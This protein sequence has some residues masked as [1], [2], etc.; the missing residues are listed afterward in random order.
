MAIYCPQC[1]KEL[2]DDAMFCIKCGKPLQG[3]VQPTTQLVPL[4]EYCEIVP[5]LVGMGFA[6][7]FWARG[8]GANGEYE[9]A[10]ST[11]TFYIDIDPVYNKV[12]DRGPNSEAALNEL[13][14][15]LSADGWELLPGKGA[16]WC[17][18][19]LR[20]QAPRN[21]QEAL[22]LCE[23]SLQ[24]NPHN[25]IAWKRKGELLER[26]KRHDEALQAY[27]QALQ[28]DPHS[29]DFWTSK[30]TVLLQLNRLDEALQAYEHA[31]KLN[32]RNVGA[33]V[34]KGD[35]LAA[36]NRYEEALKAYEKALGLNPMVRVI[37][38]HKGDVLTKL[39]RTKEAQKAYQQAAKIRE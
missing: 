36:M 38:E 12:P 8:A 28:L 7:Y 27:E 1:G 35:T 13:L 33:W 2:P 15:V 21:D 39:N 16:Y 20:R 19:K 6:S 29:G 37:W 4:W 22:A 3:S 18:Y 26:L 31:L 11:L 23:R 30:G 32:P 5:R 10:R 17:S 9:V 24:S 25:A 14:R 34:W